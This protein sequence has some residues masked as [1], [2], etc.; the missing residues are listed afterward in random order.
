MTPAKAEVKASVVGEVQTPEKLEVL[1]AS[2]GIKS[3]YAI[4]KKAPAE[5]N[6]RAAAYFDFALHVAYMSL[7]G[8]R[9]EST[10]WFQAKPERGDK[11]PIFVNFGTITAHLHGVW[12]GALDIGMRPKKPSENSPVC[13]L[14]K[15][16]RP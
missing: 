13:R 14:W 7:E 10:D 12:P 15:A 16:S 8:K 5:K 2:A 9:L 6:F 4:P 1:S 11:S 3:E